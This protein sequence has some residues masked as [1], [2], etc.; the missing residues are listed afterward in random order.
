MDIH[1]VDLA[2]WGDAVIKA[3]AMTGA[4]FG[5]WRVWLRPVVRWFRN[6]GELNSTVA[7]VITEQL[8]KMT[9]AIERIGNVQ[10]DHSRDINDLQGRV[11][12]LEGS[13]HLDDSEI[14]MT[15]HSPRT[16]R[17]RPE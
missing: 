13:A 11:H 2:Y 4:L 3:G 9:V 14:P 8:P 15:P 10:Q 12:R 16:P 7:N 17:K 5:L 6:Q 1:N